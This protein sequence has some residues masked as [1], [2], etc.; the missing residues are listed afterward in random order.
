MMQFILILPFVIFAAGMVHI[1]LKGKT[2]A[3]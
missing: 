1:S 3:R 2:G